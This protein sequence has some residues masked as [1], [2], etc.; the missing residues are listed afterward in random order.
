MSRLTTRTAVLAGII[1]AAA[2]TVQMVLLTHAAHDGIQPYVFESSGGER[3][4][5]ELGRFTVPENRSKEDSRSIQIAFVRFKSTSKSPGAP[6]VYLA[7]GPGGSGIGAARGPRFPLF[8]AM[9]ELG[10][11]IALDQ[12]GTGM[13]GFE[14][15]DC[16]DRYLIPYGEPLERTKSGRIIAEATNGCVRR[17][18]ESGIDLSA[19]NTGESAADLED[20]RKFLGVEK[21]SLWGISYGTHL[22]LTALR[23]NGKGIDRVILAGLEGPDDTYKL[24]SDQQELLE[25][26]AGIAAKDPVVSAAVPDLLGSIEKLLKSLEAEPRTVR[27][28]NPVT[29]EEADVRVG[30][31]DLQVGLSRMLRGPSTFSVMPDLVARLEQGDWTALALA[32][33]QG[34]NGEGIHGMSLAMDCASGASAERMERIAREAKTTILGD[35]INAP[36][37][38]VCEG[39]GIPDLGDDFRKPV[40]SDVPALLISGTLDGRTS[41]RNAEKVMTGLE[42]AH[43]LIIEGAGHSDPLFLSSPKILEA[44]LAFMRSEKVPYERIELPPVKLVP[45]RE[46]VA[47]DDEILSRY[48]GTYRIKGNDVRKVMKAG[49]M[50][51]TQRTGSIPLPIRP[52]SETEFFY[53]GFPFLVRFETNPGGKVT[54]M[55]MYE[56]AWAEGEPAKKIR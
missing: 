55:V 23:S 11:V 18:R 22:A 4:K 32:S 6:I 54:G 49:K 56:D 38:E 53:E 45:P 33:A 40:V 8:M 5:A 42:N 2:I 31:F 21:I 29:G 30:A 14:E 46:V 47:L 19:Y 48:V 44:M 41:V 17:L 39:Q 43:H 28:T 16:D 15:L 9:R 37:P 10:D 34:R 36:F 27:L 24:P 50:L 26:I 20:L 25:R 51:W 7:G 1:I 13:T 12:R 52:S 35:A 3:V